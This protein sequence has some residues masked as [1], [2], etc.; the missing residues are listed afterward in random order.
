[1]NTFSKCVLIITV[2]FSRRADT[3]E[4]GSGRMDVRI[5]A[6]RCDCAYLFR[7]TAQFQCNSSVHCYTVAYNFGVSPQLNRSFA[8]PHESTFF[9]FFE[10]IKL[11]LPWQSPG[12]NASFP[13]KITSVQAFTTH[14]QPYLYFPEKRHESWT[15]VILLLNELGRL[16]IKKPLKPTVT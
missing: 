9:F 1:M 11:L 13:T 14:G 16:T 8:K 2:L 12:A 10:R 7:T 3:S 15:H 4:S 6:Y 5:R